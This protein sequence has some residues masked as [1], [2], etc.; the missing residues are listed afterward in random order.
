MDA[1]SYLVLGGG[2]GSGA[3]D[4]SPSLST[5]PD[6]VTISFPP[7]DC[8]PPAHHFCRHP[9]ETTEMGS[10]L[11]VGAHRNNIAQKSGIAPRKRQRIKPDWGSAAARNI[12]PVFPW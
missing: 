7:D 11:C 3:P 8:Q 12:H 2:V 5:K 4:P 1:G 6:L 9:Q 10:H